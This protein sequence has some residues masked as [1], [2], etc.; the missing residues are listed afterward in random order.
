MLE[1][2]KFVNDTLQTVSEDEIVEVE[3]TLEG[4]GLNSH[5][6]GTIDVELQKLWVIVN[7]LHVQSVEVNEGLCSLLPDNCSTI[8]LPKNIQKLVADAWTLRGK[9]DKIED[10]FWIAVRDK[11][12]LWG[13]E[14]LQ[15]CVGWMIVSIGRTCESCGQLH[16]DE[17]EKHNTAV[18]VVELPKPEGGAFGG[19]AETIYRA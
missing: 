15:L 3:E 19:H 14:S 9:A 10:L 12:N 18:F 8:I 6:V 1:L 5:I 11:L 17:E 4:P 2:F 13:A 16:D 7:R